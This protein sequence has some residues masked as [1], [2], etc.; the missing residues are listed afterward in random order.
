MLLPRL[1]PRHSNDAPNVWFY[2][3]KA[4]APTHQTAVELVTSRLRQA[5]RFGE[6]REDRCHQPLQH[7]HPFHL[8]YYFSSLRQN[9]LSEVVLREAGREFAFH[10]MAVSAHYEVEHTNPNHADVEICPIGGRTGGY[11]GLK[12]NLVELVHDPL[13]LELMTHGTIRAA[14]VPYEDWKQEPVGSVKD[15]ESSWSVRKFGR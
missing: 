11:A 4:L 5:I 13:G 7:V 14:T 3:S 10:R 15:F 2:V 1:A 6:F 12:R 8:R 9:G